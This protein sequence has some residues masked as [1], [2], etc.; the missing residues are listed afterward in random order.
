MAVRVK[1]AYAEASEA[2]GYRVLVDRMWPRGLTKKAAR[3]D[4]WSKE[5]APSTALR[6]WFGHDPDKWDE[7]KSLYFRELDRRPDLVEA[8][9]EKSKSGPLTLVFGARDVE[10]NNAVALKEYVETRDKS[11][12]AQS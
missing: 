12:R 8:L 5:I 1:R 6:K 10:H 11:K 2:D 4:L 7:F 9:M 3:I